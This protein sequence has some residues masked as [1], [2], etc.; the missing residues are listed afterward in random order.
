MANEHGHLPKLDA[1]SL[2]PELQARLDVWYAKAYQDDN[3][4]LT[5]STSP[6]V[7]DLF[8]GW[9]SFVYG[10]TSD[11]DPAIAELCRIRSAAKAQCVH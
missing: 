6:P 3:L 8:L 10:N 1:S 9:V 2:P 7:M 4:F 11:V 5:L